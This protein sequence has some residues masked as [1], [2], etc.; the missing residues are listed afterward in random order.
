MELTTAAAQSI[1]GIAPIEVELIQREN[2]MWTLTAGSEVFYLKAHTKDWYGGV[3]SGKVV[4]HEVS[5]YRILADLELA[6]PEIVTYS[7][8]C[9]NPLGWPYF[10]MR[11]LDGVSL[12][13]APSPE[14]LRAVGAYLATMHAATFE[15]P[16]PFI[17]GP[18]AA[19]LDPDVW[20]HWICRFERKLAKLFSTW[21]EDLH[22]PAM[23]ELT[24]LFADT[25]PALRASYEPPRFVHGDCHAEQFFVVVDRVTGVVDMEIASAGSHLEDFLKFGINMA[26]NRCGFAWWEPFFDG[27]GAEPDFDLVRLI[28]AGAHHINFTCGDHPW[29]GSRA[30]IMQ[31]ILNSGDWSELFDLTRIG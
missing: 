30:Q 21:S 17:D 7:T 22:H 2:D 29:P 10:V 28:F 26:G 31:H 6:T 23:D 8:T 20:Q 13:S 18:P 5:A 14:A 12:T 9:D 3:P 1:L 19:A 24:R 25:L 16:G 4:N 11:Q 15:H 27:Y